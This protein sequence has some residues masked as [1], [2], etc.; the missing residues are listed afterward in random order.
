MASS[1]TFPQDAFSTVGSGEGLAGSAP[2]VTTLLEQLQVWAA[3]A[4]PAHEGKHS[5]PSKLSSVLDTETLR[6][7]KKNEAV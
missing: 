1:D 6:E 2:V 3:L 4:R 5:S 7:A